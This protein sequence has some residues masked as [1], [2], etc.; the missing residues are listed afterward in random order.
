VPSCST[1]RL[2]IPRQRWRP[3]AA[4][5]ARLF[6]A[7]MIKSTYGTGCL[8][9]STPAHA[10]QVDNKLLT[11]S[12]SAQGPA[13]LCVE[14]RS[15]RG[16]AV[17]VAADGL[18]SSRKPPSRPARRQSDS[19][20]GLIWCRFRRLGAPALN[21]SVRGALSADTP[22]PARELAHAAAS[23]AATERLTCGRRCAPTGRRPKRPTL[24]WRVE[25]RHDRVRLDM[26]RLADLLDAPAIAR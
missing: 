16:S 18:G 1:G 14:D 3:A 8:L 9:C 20:I 4:T 13:H 7:G 12:L 23:R 2:P 15:S 19:H 25:W 22:T 5:S 6:L 10:G 21:P 26:Q 24:C 17:Q 11:R